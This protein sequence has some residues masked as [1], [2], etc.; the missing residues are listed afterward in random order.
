M[1]GEGMEGLLDRL[2]TVLKVT[3][4]LDGME[5]G[6]GEGQGESDSEK[7]RGEREGE[8]VCVRER[9]DDTFCYIHIQNVICHKL[10]FSETA[11]VL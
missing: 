2:V 6:G 3:N 4:L 8:R 10:T 9:G 11:A 5:G 7:E 1:V